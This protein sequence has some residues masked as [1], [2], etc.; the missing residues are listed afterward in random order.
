[1]IAVIAPA[2]GLPVDIQSASKVEA[3][4][5]KG[6]ATCPRRPSEQAWGGRVA[7]AFDFL[8]VSDAAG[9]MLAYRDVLKGTAW[10]WII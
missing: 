3:C 8:E 5:N 4:A 6:V 2:G 7:P 10:S 9:E 1:M